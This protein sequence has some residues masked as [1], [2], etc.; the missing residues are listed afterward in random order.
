MIAIYGLT[1]SFS[2]EELGAIELLKSQS[3]QVVSILPPD[4]SDIQLS[5]ARSGLAGVGIAAERASED[6]LGGCSAI[7]SFGR[8]GMFACLK[9]F[10]SRPTKV[11]YSSEDVAPQE[12]E[13]AALRDGLLDEVICK[14][15]LY[16]VEYVRQLINQSGRPVEHRFGYKPFCNPFSPVFKTVM[17]G[18][19]I[20]KPFTILRDTPDSGLFAN[21]DLWRMCCGI[22]SPYNRTH[23]F[24]VLG[25]GDSLSDEAGDP[26]HP[27]CKWSGELDIEVTHGEPTWLERQERYQEASVLLHFYPA[28]EAFS[29]AA[30]RAIL[31]GAVVVGSP[32]PA[33]SSL[34]THGFSGFLATTSDEAAYLTS[35]LIWEPHV[36]AKMAADAYN[37]FITEGPGNADRCLPWWEPLLE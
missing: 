22:C 10:K 17:G 4:F 18:R 26:T 27:D 29:F 16:E 35:K 3:Q 5:Q 13:V 33:F 31:S 36:R 25:W 8:P 32:S 7:I 34:I 15:S 12:A 6:L 14:N 23:N 2:Q 11:L 28:V 30:A 9:Q 1:A 19:N 20:D 24:T 21:P 37:W